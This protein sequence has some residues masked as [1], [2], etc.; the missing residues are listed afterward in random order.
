MSR[1]SVFTSRL[2]ALLFK[3]RLERE[4]PFETIAQDLRYAWRMTLKN[5]G[6]TVVAVVS[7][8]IGIGANCAVFSAADAML[9]RPLPVPHPSEVL[10]VGSATMVEGFGVMVSSYPD[11]IDI[12]DRS[13]TFDGLVAFTSSTV[14]FATQPDALP[15]L[16]MGMLVSGNF[17]SVMGVEPQLGRAFRPEE[18]RVPGRDA[19]LILGYDF[20]EREFGAD[21]SILGRTVRLNGIEFTI[22][23]IAPPEFT[24]LD[25]FARFEFYAPLMMWPRLVADPALRPL[26][27]RGFRNV[28]IKGRL[29]SGVTLQA[30]QTELSVIAK[31]LEQAYPETNR[32]RRL[33]V[34]TELQTRIAQSPEDASLLAMLTLLA[35][36]VLLVACGNVAGLLTSRAPVRARESGPAVGHWRRACPD[37]PPTRHREHADCGP[38]RR[39]RSR[40]W[41]PRCVVGQTVSN[42]DG[43]A[44]RPIIRAG[45][46]RVARQFLRRAGERFPV[47]PGPGDPDD[48][49]GFDCGDQSDRCCR[50]RAAPAVGPR[51]AGRRTGRRFRGPARGGHVRLSGLPAATGRRSR[52]SD[53]PLAPDEF[54][55]QSRALQRCSGTTVLRADG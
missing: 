7:L 50:L 55:P 23:G 34:R 26:D 8:A 17:F 11:Y 51:A 19:V 41:L 35:A 45:S 30:A 52:P 1:F 38:R 39:R 43:S 36:A 10:T 42:P 22:V 32:N 37:R 5:P 49:R 33:A 47:R 18:N 16:R 54:Q 14:G 46:T 40:R 15:A 6:F 9:L 3:K 13:K 28:T 31:D 4:H 53:G 21:R 48:T 24:G 12:R 2:R 20:W 27:A 29:K 25:Q 44:N